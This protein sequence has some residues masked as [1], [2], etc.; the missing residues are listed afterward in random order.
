MALPLLLLITAG[1]NAQAASLNTRDSSPGIPATVGTVSFENSCK[2][3][4][5]PTLNRAIALLHSFWHDEAER[6]FDAVTAEDPQCAMAYWG[7]AMTHFHQI[8]ATPTADDIRSGAAELKQADDA[9]EKGAREA[10]YIHALELFYDGYQPDDYLS[11]A[12]RYSDAMAALTS[13]YPNDLEAQ[14]FYAL[15]LLA[16]DP[17]DDVALVNPRHAVAILQPLFREHPDHPGIAHYLIHACDNPQ[18]AREGL[19]AAL[20]YAQIAPAV[21]HAL[22]MP[23][24][25][26]ARLGFWQDDIR[27]NLASKAASERAG[28]HHGAESRLHAME[29][30]EYAYLQLGRDEEAKAILV[31]A[32]SIQPSDVDPRYPGFYAVVEARYPSIYAIETHDWKMAATLEPMPGTSPNSR[33]MTLLARAEAAGHLHDRS[34][35]ARLS[36]LLRSNESAVQPSSIRDEILAWA[37]FA[38]GDLDAASALLRPIAKQQAEIGT[39]YEVEIPAADMLADMLMLSGKSSEA[40]LQYEAT[41]KSFPNRLNTLLSAARAATQSG[42]RPLAAHYYRLAL[43]GRSKA[44]GRA[45]AQLDRTRTGLGS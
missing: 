9:H 40:L 12:R 44:D 34:E 4:V 30:L 26:F 20:R 17:P 24:H 6:A 3:A 11:H 37:D 41:L 27:S 38:Q 29:F 13:A 36:S 1:L 14:V 2:P 15:S 42:N 31:E 19:P 18:M 35:A 21:P 23:A 28:L 7:K 10:R 39:N 22:H 16:S 43:A 33:A 25:I 45:R 8:L 5:K 32:G